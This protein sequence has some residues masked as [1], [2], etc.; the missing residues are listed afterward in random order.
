MLCSLAAA[1]LFSLMNGQTSLALGQDADAQSSSGFPATAIT[2]RDSTSSYATNKNAFYVSDHNLRGQCTWYAYGR[3]V[4]LSEA[5][6]L[7]SAAATTMYNAFWG[8]TGRD[9]RNWPGFLGGEWTATTSSALPME[10]RSPGMLAVWVAGEHGHVGFV[11][12]VSVDK[13]RYRLSD[14]NR[15]NTQSHG[16]AWYNFEGTSDRLLGTYPSFYQLPLSGPYEGY[17]DGVNCD[18]VFGWAWDK[19]SPYTPI[20][21]DIYDGGNLIASSVMASDFRQDLQSSGKGNGYHAF[22]YPTPARL[23]DGQTHSVRVK[24]SSGDWELSD[25]PRTFQG[26]CGSGGT[27]AEMVNPAN[28]STFGGSSV[29]FTWNAGSGVQRYHLY[30]G[31]SQGDTDL[32]D[33]S[34]GSNLSATVTGLPTD[35]RMLYVTLWSK[36]SGTWYYNRYSYRANNGGTGGGTTSKAEMIS[37]ADGSTFSSSSVAFTWSSGSG[38][39]RYHLYVGSSQGDYDVFGASQGADLSTTVGGLPTDG[40][41]LYVRLWSRIDGNWFYNDYT[42]RAYN[43]GG[44]TAGAKAGMTTPSSGSTF[45]SSSVF[46]S[47]TSGSGVDRYHLYVGNS[48][49]ASDLYDATQGTNLSTTVSGLPTD[50]RSIYVRLWSRISN[51]WDFNDYRYSAY[52]AGGGTIQPAVITSPSPGTTFASSVVSFTWSRGQGVDEY[53]LYIGNSQGSND[54]YAR[55]QGI[56][57]STTLSGFPTDGRIIYVRLW[58]H[59]N[60]NWYYG[61]YTY[62]ASR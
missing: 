33:A 7:D 43:G 57:L 4:E 56:N 49:G 17:L 61:D 24:V 21:V 29:T 3:V 25:T 41:A 60:G 37:P 44:S 58:S 34:Q 10:K 51:N 54:T 62:R 48:V 40:R 45:S 42:Y 12:E 53:F 5:G 13:A 18:F 32:Y 59:I 20:R 16:D 9:A 1:A 35:G 15:A 6:H 19:R 46:F 22:N 50:G 27:K 36:I 47:W 30:V 2:S 14:F 23:K 55:S 11:E 26:T 39:Q 38:V 8:R 28:G 52:T 31:N